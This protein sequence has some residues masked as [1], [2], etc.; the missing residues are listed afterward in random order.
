MIQEIKMPSAGQTTDEATI[1]KVNIKVGDTVKRGDELLE[2]ETDKAI[3]PV[4][5]FAAGEVLAVLVKEGDSVTAGTVLAAIGKHGEQYQGG[6]A[7][8]AEAAAPAAAP[9]LEPAPAAVQA[10]VGQEIK[11]PSAGQTTDEATIVKVNIKVGDT[12][13]RGDE[14][15]EAE[16]DKAIL[17]VESFTAGQVFDVLVSEG[18]TVTAGTVL[19]VIGKAADA[20]A[21]H[22]GGGAPAPA[23]AP[24]TAPEAQEEYLPIIKGQSMP[25]AAPAAP[26]VSAVP[27][28]HLNLPAMPNAKMM[29][30]ELGVDITTVP[31]SNGVFVKRCDVARAAETPAAAP[32]AGESACAPEPEYEVLPMTDR[33]SVV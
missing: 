16:T 5:S 10:N 29:A 13:K 20:A 18:D 11:M 24:E 27:A 8:K 3:L 31:A 33:K 26:V 1:V 22:R 6:T 15:V 9:E 30:R 23:A 12:V 25:K 2:A 28:V 7:P 32:A 4:E 14:L 19:A 17:P 21:Y